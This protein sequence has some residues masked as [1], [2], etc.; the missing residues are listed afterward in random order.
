[1]R[2]KNRHDRAIFSDRAVAR[3]VSAAFG[4]MNR[5]RAR[6]LAA[7]KALASAEAAV[8]ALAH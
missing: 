2:R 8:A 7:H 6:F 5:R 3:R 1:M 4:T